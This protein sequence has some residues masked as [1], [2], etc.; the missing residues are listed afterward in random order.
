MVKRGRIESE[1]RIPKWDCVMPEFEFDAST[2]QNIREIRWVNIDGV[3]VQGK[4][5]TIP[6]IDECLNSGVTPPLSLGIQN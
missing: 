3:P 6:S 4:A 1:V 2:S 5:A